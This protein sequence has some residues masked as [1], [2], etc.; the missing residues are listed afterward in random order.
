MS[1]LTNMKVL[2]L[3]GGRTAKLW[4]QDPDAVETS[5][6]DQIQLMAT[7]PSLYRHLAIMPDVH[8]G[9]GATVGAVMATEGT[10][11]PNCVGVDIGCGMAAVPTGMKY[12]GAMATRE[13]WRDWI[14]G[15]QKTLPTGFACHNDWGERLAARRDRAL[16]GTARQ[17]EELKAFGSLVPA[18]KFK[19][20]DE[21]IWR[22][23]G[24]L[25]G[26]NHFVEVQRDDSGQL[27][28][29]IHSG[30]RNVGLQIANHYYKVARALNESAGEFAPPHLNFL[31]L[32]SP[33]G[34]AYLHD[35]QWAVEYALANRKEMLR[36]ALGALGLEFDEAAMI[37]IPHNYAAAE[38]HFGDEVIV[39]RKGAT[40]ARAGEVGIIPGSMGTSSYIVKGKGNAESY[41]SCS[42]GA[43]RAMGRKAA[44]RA[45]STDEF[46]RAIEGTFSTPAQGYLDEAPMAYKD[47]DH[48]MAQ[49]TELVE[50]VHTLKPV[51]TLKS[52]DDSVD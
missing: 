37:N 28:V 16:A 13:F 41:S 8:F 21:M 19:S 38:E 42:H 20:M 18:K 25:G 40:R 45:L 15:V 33:E 3:E 6:R 31:H 1:E 17:P 46:A 43:G 14:G 10:I 52:G 24:T 29:M 47:I 22:Q 44:F 23:V 32:D 34:Q 27:W 2:E 7:L 36:A 49:Q 39:H 5:A 11:V 30:S 51:I 12:E 48:V 35:M 4:V 50:I 26:G 9:M